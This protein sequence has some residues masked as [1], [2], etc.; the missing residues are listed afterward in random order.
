MPGNPASVENTSEPRYFITIGDAERVRLNEQHEFLKTHVRERALPPDLKLSQG[1]RILDSGTG[2]GAWVLDAATEAPPGSVLYGTDI[3]STTFPSLHPAN[4]VFLVHSVLSLPDEWTGTFDVVHQR[5]LVAALS[6]EEWRRALSEIYR[7]LRPGGVM[8]LEESS[9]GPIL[10]KNGQ[11]SAA[12]VPH[13]ARLEGL[14]FQFFEKKGLILRIGRSL[15]AL[16]KIAGF[17]V[18][19]HET[20][21]LP[22]GPGDIGAETRERYMAPFRTFGASFAAVGLIAPKDDWQSFLKGAEGEW[23]QNDVPTEFYTVV[24]RKPKDLP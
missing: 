20:K 13:T 3:Q 22:L 15:P 8:I 12:E 6:Q 1:A 7:I 4:T 21:V 10:S 17:Q 14:L 11:P 23:E 19:W 18:I 5:L 2:T 24:A 9:V 16:A